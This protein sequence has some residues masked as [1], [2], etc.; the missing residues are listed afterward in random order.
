MHARALG[1]WFAGSADTSML[2]RAGILEGDA[3]A[4]A[5]LDALTGAPRPLRMADAF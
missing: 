1:P 3:K 5:M 4:A 2:R